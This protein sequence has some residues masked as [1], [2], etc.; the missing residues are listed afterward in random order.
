MRVLLR[1]WVFGLVALVT[2]PALGVDYLTYRFFVHNDTEASGVRF[3]I[4]NGGA[5]R[6][7]S[8]VAYSQVN[9]NNA[10]SNYADYANA[11][12]IYYN[13]GLGSA[14][15]TPASHGSSESLSQPNGDVHVYY[16]GAPPSPTNHL[17]TYSVSWQNT[18]SW[19]AHLMMF[20]SYTNGTTE[21]QGIGYVQPGGTY[22]QLV[23]NYFTAAEYAG[24]PEYLLFDLAE[25]NEQRQLKGVFSGTHSLVH[26]GSSGSG[27]G[28]SSGGAGG[29]PIGSLTGTNGATQGDVGALGRGLQLSL[30]AL[31]AQVAKGAKEST[32]EAWTNAWSVAQAQEAA[33]QGGMTNLLE[34]IRTNL[35]GL[36][37]AAAAEA[38]LTNYLA[39]T[40][41]N[42]GSLW[43]N[44]VS[45]GGQKIG[46]LAAY[47]SGAG[48]AATALAGHIGGTTPDA[49]FG[50]LKVR[51]FDGQIIREVDFKNVV[52]LA[53]L[54][55][56]VAGLRG[57]FRS[58]VLWATILGFILWLMGEL[59]QGLLDALTPVPMQSQALQLGS[60]GG[61]LGPVGVLA[62][63]S[64]G[65][66]YKGVFVVALF[67]ALWM[68]PSILIATASTTIT[69]MGAD[70]TYIAAN[71][72]GI[73]N[74]APSVLWK[75]VFC[76]TPWLPIV[77]VGIACLNAVTAKFSI[78]GTVSFLM[79][80]VKVSEK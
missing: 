59:R 57:W 78:D 30:D 46:E 76:L 35:V 69:A 63:V 11:W 50:V 51:D 28:S 22:S 1:L 15:P 43:S 31:T 26:T 67:S 4:Y 68:L 70:P 2:F 29:N 6:H 19:G 74:D 7:D 5:K 18:N 21:T 20:W 3:A 34:Q 24:C 71:A 36:G 58:L 23:T 12:V 53:P 72:T 42:Y 8:S 79:M 27:T 14:E 65:I 56:K 47:G 61:A 39:G 41:Q 49:D 25:P 9:S 38:L 60:A 17:C 66:I 64:G 16:G 44:Y 62:G 40:N 48:G 33:R 80:Y 37:G 75:I 52:N 73:V 54:E 45:E 55:A 13:V 77:E 32:L 10:A